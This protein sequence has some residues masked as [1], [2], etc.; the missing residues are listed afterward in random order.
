MR[1]VNHR[2]TPASSTR[3]PTPSCT[4]ASWGWSFCAK[5]TR[6]A[7]CW[8]RWPGH[9]LR[10]IDSKTKEAKQM[11][12]Y[13][14]TRRRASFGFRLFF[15]S[16]NVPSAPSAINMRRRRRESSNARTPHRLAY[17]FLRPPASISI[18]LCGLPLPLAS[19]A[20]PFFLPRPLPCRSNRSPLLTP[21]GPHVFG[22]RHSGVDRSVAVAYQSP[23]RS[24]SIDPTYDSTHTPQLPCYPHNP[25]THR[26]AALG[27]P[28]NQ[29]NPTCP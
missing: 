25:A 28:P 22:V 27:P 12:R 2:S 3:R 19:L 24:L 15:L 9:E 4:R 26:T 20:G 5:P 23:A 8:A 16:L 14:C 29:P 7:C 18:Y 13:T 6:W 21:H 11:G 17:S 1:I 10:S